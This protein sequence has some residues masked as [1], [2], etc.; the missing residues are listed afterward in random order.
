MLLLIACKGDAPCENFSLPSAE[1]AGAE[2]GMKWISSESELQ[3]PFCLIKF[4]FFETMAENRG[5]RGVLEDG[6][7]ALKLVCYC[8]LSKLLQVHKADKI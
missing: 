8:I 6:L 3:V 7:K 5:F 1:L 2:S 4:C